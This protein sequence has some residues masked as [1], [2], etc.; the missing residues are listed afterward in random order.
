[1][2][3]YTANLLHAIGTARPD[4]D[5]V[6]LTDE[7]AGG[8]DRIPGIE[9]MVVG[10]TRGYRWRLWEQVGL[11]WHAARLR[12]SL[13]HSPAN[14]SPRLGIV[15]RV[16]TVHDVIPYLPEVAEATLRGRY[17]LKTVPAAIRSAAA[18]ITDSEASRR[19]IM[20]VLNVPGERIS[21]IPLAVGR[22][23]EPISSEAVGR[24]LGSLDITQP[25]VLSLA[26][27][28]PRKNTLGV[29]QVFG[30]VWRSC[31]DVQLV[32]T[33]V[34]AS[35]RRTVLDVAVREGIPENR[36][37]LL[38]Y[39]DAPTRN[40]LYGGAAV[41][42]FLTLYEGFG[43]PILE[44]MRCGTPV[45]CSNRSSCPEVAGDASVLAD[46]GDHAAAAD[47]L[48]SMLTASSAQ[49]QEWRTRG[50][51]RER[52]FTWAR[53]AEMTLRVYDAVTH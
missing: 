10:P 39:V 47:A 26:A 42:L 21:V 2:G 19:D 20:R 43:L 34:D 12:A 18:V 50:Q 49:R 5:R 33:G 13:L 51:L 9:P 44:A 40:A 7:S 6:L 35:L 3:T 11:P 52:E 14:T 4:I 41:F 1:M 29:L 45:L 32:L 38:E 28:A 15:P 8:L 27:S 36:L 24:A 16:V 53:T 17:W 23:V 31:P 46:P 37:R 30:R 22:D 48:R 25:Y